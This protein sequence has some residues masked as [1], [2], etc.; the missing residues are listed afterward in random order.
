MIS[1][2]VFLFSTTF[3]IYA[4]SLQN[5]LNKDILVPGPLLN[6]SLFQKFAS[7]GAMIEGRPVTQMDRLPPALL[8][9]QNS[10]MNNQ[11]TRQVEFTTKASLNA[12]A[13]K[14]FDYYAIPVYHTPSADL[15]EDKSYSPPTFLVE[16][17]FGDNS[18]NEGYF[19][20]SPIIDSLYR[21]MTTFIDDFPT[22]GKGAIGIKQIKATFDIDGR[23]VGFSFGISHKIPP[24]FQIPRPK[25]FNSS[26]F[27][28]ID[29]LGKVA[30]DS[31]NSYTA[32]NFSDNRSFI[33]SP[34]ITLIATKTLNAK[35][36]QDGCPVIS[37]GAFDEHTKKWKKVE[38]AREGLLDS[39][40]NCAYSLFPGHYSKFAVGGVVPPN[41]L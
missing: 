39:F 15:L 10:T 8:I 31:D 20:L 27:L 19:V 29:Y 23:N 14:L 36:L 24:Q 5:T 1:I 7:N 13:E 22:L 32:A 38:T 18:T 9:S 11:T 30:V 6:A 40:D 21:N 26:L 28:N 12:T 37:A 25:S 33:H 35:K 16:Q 4:S 17:K 34:K 2:I 41:Q 3:A